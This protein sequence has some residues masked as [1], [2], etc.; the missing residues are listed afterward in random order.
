MTLN[1]ILCVA[2][3]QGDFI[4]DKRGGAFIFNADPDHTFN[5][6]NF[7]AAI[8]AAE[9]EECARVCE[10]NLSPLNEADRYFNNGVK[11]CVAAIRKINA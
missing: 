10:S 4:A 8:A 7:A 5:V 1:N 6:F 11:T 3:E 2:K 9:R